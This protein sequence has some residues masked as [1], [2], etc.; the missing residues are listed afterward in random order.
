MARMTDM[1]LTGRVYHA[2]EGEKIGMAQY[3]VEEGQG[4]KKVKRLLKK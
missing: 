3:L 1:M 4:K 2:E